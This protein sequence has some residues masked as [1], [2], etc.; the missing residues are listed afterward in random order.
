M[1]MISAYACIYAT[2]S[3]RQIRACA[4]C[5]CRRSSAAW[6]DGGEAVAYRLCCQYTATSS[7]LDARKRPSG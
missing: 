6:F 2:H 1:M 7:S 5:L 3:I 4:M